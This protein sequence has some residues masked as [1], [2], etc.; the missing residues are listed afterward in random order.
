MDSLYNLA[1]VVSLVD[2]LTGPVKK[3]TQSVTQFEDLVQKSKA[4]IDFSNRMAVSAT[5]ISGA[6][7]AITTKLKG[8]AEPS[9]G[10]QRALGELSSVGVRDLEAVRNEA[11]KFSR[12]WSGTTEA[13][14]LTAAYDIKSG[15][16]S[17]SDQAIGSFTAMA[18]LTGKATKSS[19]EEMTSLFATGYGI[20]K[21][22]YYGMSDFEFGEM[23]SAGIAASVKS[24]KT[25][26][27]GMAQALTSL[28][29]AAATAQRPFEEQLAV[30]GMLQ[31][32]MPGGEAGTKY[33]S[34]VANAARAG[35]RLGTS[36]VDSNG[37]LLGMVE[38]I[39]L[40]KGRYGDTLDAM[41]KQE[42]AQAFGTQEAVALIDLLYGKVGDLRGN[43]DELSMSMRQGTVFTENMASTM[44][45][46]LG[47][48]MELLSQNANIVK[49]A[50]GDELSDLL[51]VFMPSVK[52][53]TSGF[54]DI[55]KTHPTLVRTLLLLS[56]IVA[57]TLSIVAPIV[58]T[59]ALFSM[60]GGYMTL[61]Y[62]KTFLAIKWLGAKSLWLIS[63]LKPLAYRYIP[64]IIAK[65]YAW[66]IALL[67][68]PVT[69]IVLGII[70]LIAVI[71][72]LWRNWDKVTEAFGIGWQWMKN[73]AADGKAY[74]LDSINGILSWFSTKYSEFKSSGAALIEAFTD[75]I[76]SAVSK[77]Y[78]AVKEGLKWVRNL[79][80][81]SDAKEGPLSSLTYSG[82]ALISTFAYGMQK[83]TPMLHKTA[84]SAFSNLVPSIVTG[85]DEEFGNW[86]MSPRPALAGGTGSIRDS[87]RE[88]FREKE[89]HTRDRRPIIVKVSGSDHSDESLIDLA[90][91]YYQ[92]DGDE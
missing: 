68:N 62:V 85:I 34:F 52:D 87:I 42:I 14:F 17:L 64:L 13:Q 36:F 43:I 75:G 48:Q 18:A 7:A 44:N 69:W 81:F 47:A 2:R 25:T 26:G 37:Q 33:R 21:D 61:A 91:R 12:V 67:T 27:S 9:I 84:L 11:T 58:M 22:L 53:M 76:K 6:A 10:V 28:G 90:Y 49:R 60:M 8:L 50:I 23:F 24:F 55:T 15:I 57:G 86:S 45:N 89:S 3:I 39:E 82:G 29:A 59:I 92:Q 65:T 5:V 56:L 80:P 16:S 54:Q 73:K 72:L 32:T 70:A 74:V 40:L 4:M 66:T 41:Q 38:I 1:V 20:Y 46:D 51:K 71:I 78:D 77:P 30:L 83:K 31:A 35:E 63:V 19:I 88:T 79:L